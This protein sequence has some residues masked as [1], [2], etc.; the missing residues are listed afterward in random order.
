M[1]DQELHLDH[2]QFYDVANQQ[3]GYV[4]GLQGQFDKQP[5]K[6][7]LTYLNLFAN[8][9]SKNSEPISDK[10]AHLT[11]YDLYDPAPDPTRIVT[12]ENQFGAQKVVIGRTYALLA[13]TQKAEPGSSFPEQLDHFKVYQVLDGEPVN[14]QITLED[15]FGARETRVYQPVFFAVPARKWWEGQTFGIHNDRAHLAIYRIYP[16]SVDKTIL[17]R[18]QFGRRYQQVFRSILLGVP[19]V[20]ESWE[21][22]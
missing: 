7:Q 17:T 12:F 20:K 6:V 14:K 8:P 5:E 9:V 22:A 21:Q 11:W 1:N 4:V 18:D 3:A 19:S 15:Q 13:P 10:N 16:G 2:F